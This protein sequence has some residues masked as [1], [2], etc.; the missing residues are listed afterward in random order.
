MKRLFHSIVRALFSVTPSHTS[1]ARQ[2]TQTSRSVALF[3][4]LSMWLC[5]L[6]GAGDLVLIRK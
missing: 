6:A 2:L 4:A 5:V 1:F 3:F